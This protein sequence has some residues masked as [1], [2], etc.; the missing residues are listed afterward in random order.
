MKSKIVLATSLLATATLTFLLIAA[1]RNSA[2][3]L[4]TRQIPDKP[5]LYPALPPK[6]PFVEFKQDDIYYRLSLKRTVFR[7]GEPI[8]IELLVE[9]R[10]PGHI[11][12]EPGSP[13]FT[14]LK[15]DKGIWHWPIS[16]QPFTL[17]IR[18]VFKP[19]LT[20]IYRVTWEQ[21]AMGK[22]KEISRGEYTLVATFPTRSYAQGESAKPTELKMTFNL[23]DR[24]KPNMGTT[25]PTPPQGEI[26]AV[27]TADKSS[28]SPGEPIEL[29]LVVTNNTS[30]PA[31][32]RNGNS[33]RFEFVARTGGKEVW[34]WSRS[35][36]FAMMVSQWD[37]QPGKS[38]TY[39]AT[40]DQKNDSYRQV[41]AGEYTLEGW[42]IGGGNAQ[43]KIIIK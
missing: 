16:S 24:G 41:P 43:V 10:A 40:W 13:Q 5:L 23:E 26:K 1:S 6:P 36:A 30:Q 42:Q 18:E 2:L 21:K 22:N 39:E 15:A 12:F 20:K 11:A 14:I 4:Q 38:I 29:Q 34:H 27:L 7:K 35:R 25:K 37:I 17:S 33:Q 8:V 3:A 31:I 19:G 9:N 28:Y 32:F